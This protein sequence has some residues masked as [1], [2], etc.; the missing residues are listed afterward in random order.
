MS[1]SALAHVGVKRALRDEIGVESIDLFFEHFL[2]YIAYGHAFL[3]HRSLTFKRF[4]KFFC[5]IEYLDI[6]PIFFA[7]IFAHVRLVVGAVDAADVDAFEFRAGRFEEIGDDRRIGAAGKR[8]KNLF[9][10]DEFFELGNFLFRDTV[11][12]ETVD[13]PTY[14]EEVVVYLF[15]LDRVGH[16]RMELHTPQMFEAPGGDRRIIC[17]AQYL[18]HA[19]ELNSIAVAFKHRCLTR[20]AFKK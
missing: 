7:E 11:G 1:V 8:D 6:Y 14:L 5:R 10:P 9:I 4:Q 18:Y 20:D 16:F 3:T 17:S 19:T 15:S 2:V 12:G 13:D